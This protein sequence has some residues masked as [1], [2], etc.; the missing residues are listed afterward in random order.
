MIAKML[1]VCVVHSSCSTLLLYVIYP[2]V[3]KADCGEQWFNYIETN[4]INGVVGWLF[5][6]VVNVLI[7]WLENR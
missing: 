3:R 4:T 2:F 7:I 1:S 5:V 6:G